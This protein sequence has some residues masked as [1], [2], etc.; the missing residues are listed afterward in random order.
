VRDY[1]AKKVYDWEHSQSWWT[2]NSYLTEEQVKKCIQKLDNNLP[3]IILTKNDF[4]TPRLYINK[5]LQRKRKT[6]IIFSNGRGSSN[7]TGFYKIKLK[8]QWALNYNV[9]LHEYAHL[10]TEDHHGANFV[11]VYCCLL[12]A[13][14]PHQ[15][16]FKE[17]AKSLNEH[18]IDFKEFDYTW[19]LL[20][21]SKRIKPFVKCNEEPLPKPTK[22]TRVSPKQKLIKLC[23]EH[24][25]L[26]Y[27]DDCGFE[28]F[29]CEVWDTRIEEYRDQ[30]FDE[31]T[32]YSDSW[33][34]AYQYA[35]ELVERNK[36]YGKTYDHE[37]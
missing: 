18:N 2:W 29:K 19:K 14:H 5:V 9:I 36:Q 17:L 34:M 20:K 25:W 16:T 35:L 23:E 10:L 13:Y 32:D 22:K 27:N 11:S 4:Y 37:C 8:R 26:E 1:Q 30:W 21:L 6:K 15:P 24:D 12:V 3:N 28:W 31:M 33:K 7:A